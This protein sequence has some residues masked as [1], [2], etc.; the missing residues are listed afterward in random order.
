MVAG[1][2]ATFGK[3]TRGP[4]LL[5]T[6][7]ETKQKN[8]R[9]TPFWKIAARFLPIGAQMAALIAPFFGVVGI[10]IGSVGTYF[11]R[12]V[13]PTRPDHRRPS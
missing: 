10:I 1:S 6:A 7:Q 9:I 3:Q 5:E 13:Q 4:G 11:D 12:S 2:A 8:R